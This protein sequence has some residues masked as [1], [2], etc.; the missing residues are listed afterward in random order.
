MP[1]LFAS[2]RASRYVA[3]AA[4]R[5][6]RRPWVEPL[7]DRR[8]LAADPLLFIEN[9]SDDYNPAQ[10]GFDQADDDPSTPP[11]RLLIQHTVNARNAQ[12]LQSPFVRSDST[13]QP[14]QPHAFDIVGP[15]TDTIH[16]PQ[17]G[18][19]GGLA[20]GEEITAV[21]IGYSG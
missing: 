2:H 4:A 14:S 12:F 3:R 15:G 20:A 8:L 11:D 19:P 16:W 9:F 18:T 1:T 13:F 21:S 5:R 17:A 7:E 6:H 10:P